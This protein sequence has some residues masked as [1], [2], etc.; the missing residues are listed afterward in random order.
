MH[1]FKHHAI[2]VGLVAAMAGTASAAEV[3]LVPT[4]GGVGSQMPDIANRITGVIKKVAARHGL[5]AQVSDASREDVLA[6]AGCTADTDECHQ[7]VMKTLD[8][9]TLILV[10]VTPGSGGATADVEI[11]VASRGKD[12]VKV[13]I[14]L[15]S[16]SADALLAELESKADRAFTAG[17]AG[18]A[19][20]EEEPEV[21]AEN[22]DNSGS[23]GPGE[24]GSF[25]GPTGAAP[26]GDDAGDPGA[27]TPPAEATNPP[28]DDGE[29][30]GGYDLTRVSTTTWAIGGASVGVFVIGVAFLR[31]A[32]GRE[33]DARSVRANTAADID[34]IR[35]IESTGKTYNSIGNTGL[36]LG[37]AG[38]G[39]AGY[40]GYREARVPE[41]K[42]EVTVG[43]ARF[44]DG[45][46]IVARF[47]R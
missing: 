13:G 3:V 24:G 8:A 11:I 7:A 32:G 27:A 18:S 23:L 9:S 1:K 2:A 21:P 46:G 40:L 26:P 10:H 6:V 15:M 44:G 20:I 42:K 19:P 35:E 45:F 38:L 30:G 25:A 28:A 14:P 33:D 4:S 47:R 22:R 43:P 17:A 5:L 41:S 29:P 34:R 12:P 36:F 16:E 39:V 37:L 31:A